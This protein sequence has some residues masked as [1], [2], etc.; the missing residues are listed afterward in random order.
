MEPDAAVLNEPDMRVVPAMSR[1]DV[2][3]LPIPTLLVKRPVPATSNLNPAFVVVPIKTF[4]PL[5][6][7]ITK[8]PLVAAF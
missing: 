6:P 1:E 2:G 7:W 5:V 8:G 4:P 3:V